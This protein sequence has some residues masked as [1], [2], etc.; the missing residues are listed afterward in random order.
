MTLEESKFM[1]LR[2]PLRVPGLQTSDACNSFKAVSLSTLPHSIFLLH[3][4]TAI[5]CETPSVENVIVIQVIP[6]RVL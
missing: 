2:C 4:A 5:Y 1:S 6:A 3:R